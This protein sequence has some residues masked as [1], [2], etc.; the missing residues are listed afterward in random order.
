I[1]DESLRWL[2]EMKRYKEAEFLIKKMARINQVDSQ[3]ALN[4]LKKDKI[5][6]EDVNISNGSQSLNK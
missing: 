2:L 6:L 3:K 1:V 5:V 4:L